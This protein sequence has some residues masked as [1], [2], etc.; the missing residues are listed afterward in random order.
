MNQAKPVT[1]TA[2]GVV[3][4]ILALGFLYIVC[5]HWTNYSA[6]HAL[7]VEHGKRELPDVQQIIGLFP[8]AE[9]HHFITHFG[10]EES[11]PVIWNTQVFFR[12]RYI[13]TYQVRVYV[14]YRKNTIK[15]IVDVPDFFLKEVAQSK[16]RYEIYGEQWRFGKGQWERIVKANGDFT[17]GGIRLKENEP[18]AGFEELVRERRE[19]RQ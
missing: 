18:V 11:K 6:K 13:L 8:T 15:Q 7:A 19:I 17:A 5:S 12:G 1:R 10:H 4:G 2:V 3:C 9:I 14:D 16:D